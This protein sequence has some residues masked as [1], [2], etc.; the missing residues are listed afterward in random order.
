MSFFLNQIYLALLLGNKLAD[1]IVQSSAGRLSLDLLGLDHLLV[2][3]LPHKDSLALPVGHS[4]ARLLVVA[5]L[6]LVR[7]LDS[8]SLAAEKE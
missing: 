3:A 2:A 4:L 1:I 5:L 6:S 8:N 7:D